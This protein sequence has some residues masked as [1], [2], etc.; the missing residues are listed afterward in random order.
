MKQKNAT[1]LLGYSFNDTYSKNDPQIRILSQISRIFYRYALCGM[2]LMMHRLLRVRSKVC[3]VVK[4]WRLQLLAR[5]T[6]IMQ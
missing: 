6:E 4:L 3:F 5:K 2:T 1:K